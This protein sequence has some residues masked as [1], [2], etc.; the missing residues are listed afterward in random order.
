MARIAFKKFKATIGC[1][2]KNKVNSIS[3]KKTLKRQTLNLPNQIQILLFHPHASCLR[4]FAA[5][6]H[7][8]LTAPPCSPRQTPPLQLSHRH[9][10]SLILQAPPEFILFGF[11]TAFLLGL[12]QQQKSSKSQSCEKAQQT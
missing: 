7:H 11:F 4:L 8:Q 5:A 3:E 10:I 1:V 12:Y 2:I 9:C 6:K